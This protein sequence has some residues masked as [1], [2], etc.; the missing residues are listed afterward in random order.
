M[1]HMAQEAGNTQPQI[2]FDALHATEVNWKCM[3]EMLQ[4]P[5]PPGHMFIDVKEAVPDISQGLMGS[6]T[7]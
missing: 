7:C 1:K 6:N 4:G 5:H 3:E 2:R